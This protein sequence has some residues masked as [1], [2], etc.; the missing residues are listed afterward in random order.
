MNT[1]SG[2]VVPVGTPAVVA[3]LEV[4]A[5]C[6]VGTG[7]PPRLAFI[8]ICGST[9]KDDIIHMLS[10]GDTVY[11]YGNK[12]VEKN[13]SLSLLNKTYFGYLSVKM[14]GAHFIQLC[15]EMSY[16]IMHT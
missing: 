8:N 14:F 12:K 4:E 13:T 2:A 7:V 6:V 16:Y 5:H 9:K 1:V 11:A 15:P 10:A 3:S